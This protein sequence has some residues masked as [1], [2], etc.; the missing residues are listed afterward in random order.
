MEMAGDDPALMSIVQGL[1]KN[2]ASVRG[3]MRAA[4]AQPTRD[5]NETTAETGDASDDE[6]LPPS[7]VGPQSGGSE[8]AE[9]PEGLP[10]CFDGPKKK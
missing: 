6:G 7:A 2:P 5:W 9:D 10:P 3:V 1:L 8:I 4:H